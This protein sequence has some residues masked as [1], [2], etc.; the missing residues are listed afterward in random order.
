MNLKPNQDIDVR[1]FIYDL[2]QSTSLKLTYINRNSRLRRL[3]IDK[4]IVLEMLGHDSSAPNSVPTAIYS[5]LTHTYDFE[6]EVVYAIGLDGDTDIIGAMTGAISGGFHGKS[7]IP[8]R[9]LDILEN[10]RKNRD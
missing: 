4:K 1:R 8:Y 7:R 5:F 2:L 10:G 9:W 6:E 3:Q